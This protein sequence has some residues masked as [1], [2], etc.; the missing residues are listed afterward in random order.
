MDTSTA[1]RVGADRRRSRVVLD[2]ALAVVVVAWLATL[3][4][5]VA[6]RG[7]GATGAPA[8][9]EVRPRTE[10]P[11][12]GEIL[13]QLEVE[14]GFTAGEHVAYAIEVENTSDHAVRDLQMSFRFVDA[15][16]ATVET[17]G[18]RPAV[19]R[20]LIAPVLTSATS[21]T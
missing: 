11:A 10:L 9:G 15:S 6:R 20:S 14:T 4:V 19:M 3:V 1:A 21:P 13:D 18:I 12:A 17:T 8:T 7:D 16:G 5:V 2:V